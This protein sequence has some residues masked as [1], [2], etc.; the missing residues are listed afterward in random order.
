[1]YS[2]DMGSAASVVKQS[3]DF[4]KRQYMTSKVLPKLMTLRTLETKKNGIVSKT[5]EKELNDMEVGDDEDQ[6][7]VETMKTTKE[8]IGQLVREAQVLMDRGGEVRLEQAKNLYEQVVEGREKLLG[9]FHAN[10]LKS[11]SVLGSILHKLNKLPKA[12]LEYEKALYGYEQVFGIDNK[13]TLNCMNSLA[14]VLKGLDLN[15]EAIN[16]FKECLAGK[17]RLYGDHESTFITA[18]HLADL[19]KKTRR[20]PEARDVYVKALQ[21]I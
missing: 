10:T 12:R 2:I 19:L 1:M 18:N 15:E 4:T 9:P 20:I 6:C 14:E 3:Y 16:M 17:E 13:D 11:I 8:E 21:G 7:P 5:D